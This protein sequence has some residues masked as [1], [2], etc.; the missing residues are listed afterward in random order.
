ME[1]AL[2]IYRGSHVGTSNSFMHHPVNDRCWPKVAAHDYAMG[3]RSGSGGAVDLEIMND[4]FGEFT[5]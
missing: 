3:V 1:K 5:V 2:V 4:C